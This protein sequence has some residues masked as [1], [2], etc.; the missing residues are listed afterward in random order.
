MS[1]REGALRRVLQ[2][3][4]LLDDARLEDVLSR[5]LPQLLPELSAA[6]S[7]GAGA[8]AQAVEVMQHV[9]QRALSL[10]SMR[11][12]CGEL[13][14]LV[15]AA[16]SQGF[17]LSFALS[18]LAL[19]FPREPADEQARA[20]A[21]LV[22][23]ARTRTDSQQHLVVRLVLQSLTAISTR[24]ALLST[25]FAP[26]VSGAD[27]RWFLDLLLD[28]FQLTDS[29]RRSAEM[30][31]GEPNHP[32][33]EMTL[34]GMSVR[35]VDR[36]C[37][38]PPTGAREAMSSLLAE[39]QMAA[40]RVLAVLPGVSDSP[41]ALPLLLVASEMGR[42]HDIAERA[43]DELRRL[44]TPELIEEQD[45]VQGLLRLVLGGAAEEPEFDS[46]G[47]CSA[48]V[49]TAALRLL[50]RSTRAA[51]CTEQNLKI[52]FEALF[53]TTSAD[54]R[55]VLR[56]QAVTLQYLSW[57]LRTATSQALPSQAGA[58]LFGGLR[59]LL[60][61]RYQISVHREGGAITATP[62]QVQYLQGM[63]EAL[64]ALFARFPALFANDLQLFRQL[65]RLLAVEPSELQS[66]VH[67]CCN[68]LRFSYDRK[69][70]SASVRQELKETLLSA[71]LEQSSSA[72]VRLLVVDWCS[73]L[74]DTTD[75]LTRYALTV[76]T[77]DAQLSV[78][79]AA[80][81][82]MAPL[83][84]PDQ[85]RIAVEQRAR[86][87]EDSPAGGKRRKLP[88]GDALVATDNKKNSGDSGLNGT[89]GK[90]LA[91][92]EQ[93][94]TG[95]ELGP[96]SAVLAAA[97]DM[98]RAFHSARKVLCKYPVAAST[99][100]FPP[101]A[102]FVAYAAA[103]LP[104]ANSTAETTEKTRRVFPCPHPHRRRHACIRRRY[105]ALGAHHS[106]RGTARPVAI[107]RCRQERRPGMGHLAAPPGR[108]RGGLERVRSRSGKRLACA[109]RLASRRARVVEERICAAA[110]MAFAHGARR[111]C[112]RARRCGS[113]LLATL[114][115]GGKRM[116]TS[117]KPTSS[118]T[119][120]G[121]E[122]E[123]SLRRHG[124]GRLWLLVLL[125]VRRMLVSRLR[126][127]AISWR[128][129]WI[130]CAQPWHLILRQTKPCAS[131]LLRPLG[132]RPLAVTGLG[133]CRTNESR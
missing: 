48:A 51:S 73:S 128:P 113:P 105:L 17:T 46:R 101:F 16:D 95:R 122:S 49:R 13:V 43:K 14:A 41:T 118:C 92:N 59:Q 24:P 42:R 104:H 90:P 99:G 34:P 29:M 5:L 131:Q 119:S 70:A 69:L 112:R 117:T 80:A 85:I 35:R 64:S 76:A 96:S 18:L 61:A 125:S 127:R 79:K 111:V 130:R 106:M 58:I 71:E 82:A 87:V 121:L 88:E 120:L 10:P 57:C 103:P 97:S 38:S 60:Y 55:D 72:R 26:H 63:Y 27:M 129:S 19:G 23:N 109:G 2:R 100:H 123:H 91:T 93:A 65:V 116:A 39:W 44:Q 6:Q 12:P 20:L 107:R 53:G 67:E 124:M 89:H 11:L 110:L 84:E 8:R 37:A 132:A 75:V 56:H 52:V 45:A 108:S 1:A 9:M 7:E 83:L 30:W 3:L 33:R 22:V 114:W 86:G 98:D 47:P 81:H 102:D 4:V 66:S 68:I 31:H 54:G 62:D 126:R 21:R 77:H 115:I 40:V 32:A 15:S 74:F 36:L 25:E 28:V 78:R 50:S 133:C 94:P